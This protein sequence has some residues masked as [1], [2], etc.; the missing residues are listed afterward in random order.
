MR[1][2]DIPEIPHEFV[3][4]A[5]M[6]LRKVWAL[7]DLNLNDPAI[8]IGWN[9]GAEKL[10][11]PGSKAMVE[12]PE[13]DVSSQLAGVRRTI[14]F[15]TAGD[16]FCNI[17]AM[18]LVHFGTGP[19]ATAFG[20]KVVLRDG[21][22]PAFIPAVH[23]PK[24]ASQLEKPNLLKDGMCKQILERI[25]YYN[26]ATQGKIPL[27]V[28]DC[29]G[30]WSVAT[31]IWHYEDMLEAIYTAPEV[32]HSFMDLVTDCL[33]EFTYIQQERIVNYCG[34]HTTTGS[35][36]RPRGWGLGDDTL[37]TVSPKHFQE[38]F[39]P[40]NERLSRELGGITY[41]CCMR[42]DFQLESIAKTEGFMGFDPVPEYNDLDI[43]E[44]VLS[45]KGVWCCLLSDRNLIKRFGGKVGIFLQESGKSRQDALDNVAKLREFLK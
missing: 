4:K 25:E 11:N 45:G 36:W 43:I 16:G 42:Y 39:M 7:E 18:N 40:Y 12:N 6:K 3:D 34:Y 8:F 10:I 14:E 22:Q 20:S 35:L 9:E 41:H 19:L 33:I 15:L 17:P 21:S 29:A 28:S 26:E 31:Q 24:E 1:K 13:L 30:P 38:F 5:K 27:T 44:R 23:T 37:V 32:V 2:F